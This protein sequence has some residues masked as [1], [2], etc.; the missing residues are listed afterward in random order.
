MARTLSR[1][2]KDREYC[3]IHEFFYA[4]TDNDIEIEFFS[5]NLSSRIEMHDIKITNDIVKMI[6]MKKLC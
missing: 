1:R 3:S 6:M 2:T 4:N 5:S